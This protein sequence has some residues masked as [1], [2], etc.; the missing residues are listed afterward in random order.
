MISPTLADRFGFFLGIA[1]GI[2]IGLLLS[3]ENK[4]R[5]RWFL[6]RMGKV[7]NADDAAELAERRS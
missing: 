3:P 7:E 1:L 2:P 6:E 5:L 4:R